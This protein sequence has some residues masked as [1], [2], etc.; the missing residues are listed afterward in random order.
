MVLLRHSCLWRRCSEATLAST[1]STTTEPGT[2]SATSSAWPASSVAAATAQR[3]GSELPS[4]TDAPKNCHQHRRGICFFPSRLPGPSA[5]SKHVPIRVS[6]VHLADIPRHV[7]RRKSDI[8]PSAN[9]LPVDLIHVVPPHR[10]PSALVAR[11][12]SI[13]LKRSRIRSPAA[14]ALRFQAKKNLD[15]ARPHRPESRRRSPIPTF[16][17]APLRKPSKARGHVGYIQYRRNVF[18]L[19]SA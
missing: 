6:H 7:R 4:L 18:C 9:A 15:L 14:P 2:T 3:V 17:P 13:L 12:V 8:Q 16:P 11:F 19:H 5:N 10:H 1:R